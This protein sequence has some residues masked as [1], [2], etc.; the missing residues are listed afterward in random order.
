MTDIIV[1]RNYLSNFFHSDYFSEHNEDDHHA[2]EDNEENIET[3]VPL[4]RG[5]KSA[6]E[7]EESV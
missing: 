4:L 5:D 6:N 7:K 2:E 1:S 3:L